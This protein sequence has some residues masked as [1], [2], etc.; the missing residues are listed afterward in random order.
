VKRALSAF[1]GVVV[2]RHRERLGLSQENLA[3]RAGIHR[4][5][6]SSIERG[7]VRLGL[8]IAKNIADGLGIPLH[9]LIADAEADATW[10]RRRSSQNH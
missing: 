3:A 10:A 4:T 5:Y 9:R 7:R 1:F 2:R 6:V 8:D